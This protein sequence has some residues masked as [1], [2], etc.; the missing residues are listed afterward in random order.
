MS[1]EDV[2]GRRG[3]HE[4]V[5]LEE[6]LRWLAPSVGARFLDLTVGAGGHARGILERIGPTGLLVGV[7]RD[8]EVLADTSR[9]LKQEFPHAR[10]IHANFAGIGEL[11]RHLGP[12]TFHGLLLDLGASS[13]QLDDHERGFSFLRSGPLDMRMD[14]TEGVTAAE[15]L[16]DSTAEE[17]ERLLRLYGEE[18]HARRIARA[19]VRERE[20]TALVDTAQLAAVIERASLSRRRRIHPATRSFQALRI[21]VNDEL[22][23]LERFL[24]GFDRLL[25]PQG[26]IVVISFHSLEDRLVKQCFRSRAREGRLEVLTPKPIR[27]GAEETRRNRRARSARLRA[28][29]LTA[30]TDEPGEGRDD[31]SSI[32]RSYRTGRRD[33]DRGRP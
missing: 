29:R 26:V 19:I 22:G 2:D 14:R 32:D 16:R 6:V 13:M 20:R 30:T 9:R 15:L 27:A 21:A 31:A 5:M 17:L 12:I 3:G 4:P 23:N 8:E 7:D 18:R 28:A 25:H 11:R 33:G 10:F 1:S 24:E